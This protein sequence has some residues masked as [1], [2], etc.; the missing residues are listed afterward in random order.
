VRGAPTNVGM[1]YLLGVVLTSLKW[2]FGPA[3][4]CSMFSAL[5]F[6]LFS[7]AAISG[8]CVD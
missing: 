1:L 4:M 2:G 3:L 6:A 7:Y 8:L 5:T